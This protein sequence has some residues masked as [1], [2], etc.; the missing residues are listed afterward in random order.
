MVHSHGHG[1][2][3]DRRFALAVGLNVAL[4]VM[5][6][7]C[8]W[9]ADS[10]A[11]LADAGHNLEDVLGLLLAWGA[12]V[13][14]KRPPT[15]RHTFGLRRLTILAALLNS[16]VLLIVL[17]VL[18]WEAARR[19]AEPVVPAGDLVIAA[20]AVG[21]VVN[22]ATAWL[23]LGDCQ[24]DL[25]IRAAFVHMVAD[26][27]LSLAVV[28]AGFGIRATGWAW[29][30]PTVSLLITAAIAAGTWGVL[31]TSLDLALDAVPEHVDIAAVREYLSSLPGIVDVH[32]LH[33]WATSTTQ[34]S[35]TAHLVKPDAQLDDRLLATAT[36]ELRDRF[37]I[38]HATL[39]LEQGRTDSPC[40]LSEDAPRPAVPA[41]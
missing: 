12:S 18:G 11:L 38:E 19:F 23:F 6:A 33:V 35:L 31:R 14:G 37:G 9:Y 10:L 22:G 25:N 13:L 29:I 34:A 27:A 36:A 20:A 26:A 8:G 1:R 30:D 15:E 2:N 32:D 39:Q 17:F 5:E 28:A 7:A 24:H 21:V 40:S 3:Y 41:T 4:V 16:A